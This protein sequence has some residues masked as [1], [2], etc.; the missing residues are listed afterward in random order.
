[1]SFVQYNPYVTAWWEWEVSFRDGNILQAI[2]KFS[3]E[4]TAA[5]LPDIL[6]QPTLAKQLA[7]LVHSGRGIHFVLCDYHAPP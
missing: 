1:M 3:D 5:E 2:P 6:S 4:Q 7:N